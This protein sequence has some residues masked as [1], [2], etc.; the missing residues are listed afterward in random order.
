MYNQKWCRP[1]KKICSTLSNCHSLPMLTD[2]IKLAPVAA[3]MHH[4]PDATVDAGCKAVG[5]VDGPPHCLHTLE[6][7]CALRCR[8]QTLLA[9]VMAPSVACIHC[10][11]DATL[12]AGCKAAGT[13]NGLPYQRSSAVP[14]CIVSL[15]R[16][17]MQAASLMAL[18]MASLPRMG[19]NAHL[20]KRVLKGLAAH[21]PGRMALRHAAAKWQVQLA[22]QQGAPAPPGQANKEA[23]K[24]AA[25]QLWQMGTYLQHPLLKAIGCKAGLGHMVQSFELVP[26]KTAGWQHQLSV[27]RYAWLQALAVASSWSFSAWCQCRKSVCINCCLYSV[28]KSCLRRA[29]AAD[30]SSVSYWSCRGSCLGAS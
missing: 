25:T 12:D 28:L 16:L 5:A 29:I 8:L 3:C 26:G 24:W 21:V 13:I 27:L 15:M 30:L 1:C 11:P 6:A 22:Q 2:R 7:W 17:W 9:L 20:A 23:L 19:P 10:Q 18:L 4:R 14:A